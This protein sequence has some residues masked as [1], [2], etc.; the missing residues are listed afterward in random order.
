MTKNDSNTDQAKSGQQVLSDQPV[1]NPP[2]LFTG[3]ANGSMVTGA[4]QNSNYHPIDPNEPCAARPS[5]NQKTS[6][7]AAGAKIE[8]AKNTTPEYFGPSVA[9]PP[10]SQPDKK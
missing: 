8:T 3:D 10:G 7:A 9:S 4:Q 2:V 6:D 1:C 5:P